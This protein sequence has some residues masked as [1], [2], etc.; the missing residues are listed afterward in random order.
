MVQAETPDD[1]STADPAPGKAPARWGI[2]ALAAVAVLILLAGVTALVIGRVDGSAPAPGASPSHSTR[3]V[4]CA[5]AGRLGDAKA[6]RGYCDRFAEDVVR[7]TE[8]TQ[9]QRD[10]L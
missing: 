10:R 9:D 3:Y 5:Y 1:L 7:R 2:V 6:D 8:L 4:A